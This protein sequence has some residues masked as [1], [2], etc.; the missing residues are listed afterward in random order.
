MSGN[1]QGFMACPRCGRMISHHGGRWTRHGMTVDGSDWCPMSKQ[2]LPIAGHKP[3]D[4]YHRASLVADLASQLQDSDPAV[5][6]DYLTTIPGGELQRL[7]MIALAGID[8]DRP[9][10]DIWSWVLELPVARAS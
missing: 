5:V 1:R 4:Y 8:V 3:I 9:L 7:L 2:T 6:W 10:N